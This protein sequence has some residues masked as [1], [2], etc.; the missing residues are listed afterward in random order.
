MRNAAQVAWKP[1]VLYYVI[2]I[3][4]ISKYID[5][6]Y[7]HVCFILSHINNNMNPSIIK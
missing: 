7:S 2:K 4:T 1:N 3:E 5:M 6:V